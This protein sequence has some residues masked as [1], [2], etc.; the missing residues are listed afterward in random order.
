MKFKIKN[1]IKI[2]SCI[3]FLLCV[4]IIVNVVIHN[5]SAQTF[6]G[7]SKKMPIYC[8]DTKEKRVAISFDSCSD[9]DYTGEI[10]DI[11][12][13][14]NVKADFFLV[15]YYV[16]K[17]PDMVKEIQKRGHEIGNHSNKHPDMAYS[18]K[19]KIVGDISACDTKIMN[20]TGEMP[21]LFRFPS[22]SYNDNAIAAAE[23]TNHLCIQWDVDSIDWKEKGLDIEYNR[24][25]TKTKPGSILLFHNNAKYTPKNLPRIIEKLKSEGYTFVKISDLLY[26]D[27]YKLDISGKQIK[28]Y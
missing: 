4:P 23:S 21:K 22:G 5:L 12:D 24:I 25:V 13:K 7:G 26:K 14:Y 9:P 15:G 11:L 1:T 17:H 16:D 6:A 2:I 20:V 27:N 28:N 8:V 10:L 3:L 19:E 18:S